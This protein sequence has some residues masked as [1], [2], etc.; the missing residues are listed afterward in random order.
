MEFEGQNP[1]QWKCI[2]PAQQTK[3]FFAAIA[4][5]RRWNEMAALAIAVPHM[6]GSSGLTSVG[7]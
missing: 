2:S 5:H 7:L 6:N 4:R 1:G 3:P